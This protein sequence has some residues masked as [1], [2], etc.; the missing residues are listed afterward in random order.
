[1][2]KTSF[3]RYWGIAVGSM[4]ALTGM[5]LIFEPASVLRLL[6]IEASSPDA[7]VFLSWIGV[8][9]MAVGL[10][11]GF[12]LGKH[13]GAGQAVWRFTSLVRI[14]VVVFLVIQIIR[15]NMA[16]AWMAVALFDGFV[17]MAQMV[18][19]RK[20]WWREAQR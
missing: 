18:M 3:L 7:M 5:L 9:V 6:K 2:T 10:S 11:Y 1:M 20:S 13:R 16:P 19:L 17:A 14:L 15:E 4:D 8:F 12:A